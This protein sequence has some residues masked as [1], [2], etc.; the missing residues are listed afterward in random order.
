MI[1]KH[2]TK[3][4][5][6][7]SGKSALFAVLILML[8]V[9]F[10]LG[11][12][13]WVS[14]SAFLEDCEDEYRTIAFFEYMSVEYPDETIRDEGV[15]DAIQTLSADTIEALPGVL[16]WQ[17]VTRALGYNESFKNF[18]ASVA[19]LFSAA[20]VVKYTGDS[21][22]YHSCLVVDTLYCYSDLEGLSL[23]MYPGTTPE[24]ERGHYYLMAGSLVDG[25]SSDK[26]FSHGGIE[27]GAAGDAGL[28]F[29]DSDMCVDITGADG[30]SWSI[31]DD[32]Q[33]PLIAETMSVVNNHMLVTATNDIGCLMPF[34]QDTLYITEGRLFTDAEYA[35]GALSCVVSEQLCKK[36]DLELGDS[37]SISTAVSSTAP[38]LES[39][40]A[41]TGFEYEREYIIVGITN[42]L[43]EYSNCVYIPSSGDIDLSTNHTGYTVGTAVLD[44]SSA[45]EFFEAVQGILP[46]RVIVS[47]YDQ[48]YASVAAP[49]RDILNV[50]IVVTL[51][52]GLVALAVLILFGYLFV[53]RQREVSQIMIRLG[54]GKRRTRLYFLY[55]SGLIALIASAVGALVGLLLS[56][57]VGVLVQ[58]FAAG[59]SSFDAHYSNGNLSIIKPLAYSPELPITPFILV[60]VAVFL[61]ALLSCFIFTERSFAAPQ[62][63]KKRVRTPK[64]GRS[65][66]MRGGAVKYALLSIRRGG[67]RTIA[68]PLLAFMATLFLCQLVTTAASYETQLDQIYEDTTISG[69]L[70]D[71]H[72][73]QTGE[74]VISG[75]TVNSLSRSGYIEDIALSKSTIFDTYDGFMENGR[76]GGFSQDTYLAR[77]AR[78][79]KL[80]YT[81]DLSATPEFYY[82]SVGPDVSY[83]EGYDESFLSSPRDGRTAV[84]LDKH[85]NCV[86]PGSD[87]Y[88]LVSND[89][90][91]ENKLEL[92]DN[93]M[94]V[95]LDPRLA[96]VNLKIIGSFEKQGAKDNIYVELGVYF[97]PSWITTEDERITGWLYTWSFYS[98]SFTLSDN[99]TLT[100]LKA[101]LYDEGYSEPTAFRKNR[102]FVILQDKS[103]LATVGTIEQQIEY[104]GVLYPVLYAL[105]GIIGLVAAYLLILS[106]KRE[107]A[108]MRGLGA[109]RGT[110]FLSLFLEQ[111]ALCITG[112][113]LGLL[114]ALALGSLTALGATLTAAFALCW[115]IGSAAAAVGMNGPAVLQILREEE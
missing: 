100:E 87:W 25:P 45:D 88:C 115:V 55:G 30:K 101:S 93:L 102:S 37:F 26:Y 52:C 19:D 48:G 114:I 7:A 98:M 11:V 111:V 20:V 5:L 17:S 57:Q 60:G 78:G 73:R 108:I 18:G 107:L 3:N 56:G 33:I 39:Y 28:V 83:L 53:Y 46:D 21:M 79:G 106:R 12:S 10:S 31:P 70:A 103:F 24:L 61:L 16:E 75:S 34:H 35:S 80:I 94:I 29:D 50:A 42:T 86:N 72:G 59:Y 6:R 22:G 13:V 40:W 92:G 76:S 23:R 82:S 36:L 38:T 77:L 89:Y 43:T 99:T 64:A 112:C 47:I 49:F 69:A 2:S 95:I 85:L 14:I 54:A 4:I 74:V 104:V 90:L 105:T 96:S 32:S 41:G 110:S 84:S 67:A 9:V 15:D 71:S 66:T 65:S 113:A 109:T 97:E 81:N 51:V 68:S 63:K 8:T 1:F 44:N 58:S 91:K 27:F 62:K